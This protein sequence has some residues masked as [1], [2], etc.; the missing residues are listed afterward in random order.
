[1]D[2]YLLDAKFEVV[3]MIDHYESFI[4]SDR[5]NSAGEFELY[6]PSAS[7]L[8]KE[9][10]LGQYIC[11]NRSDRLMVVEEIESKTDSY[12]GDHTIVTG[13]SLESLLD[14]RVIWGF[15]EISGNLQ[16]GIQKLLNENVISPSESKRKIPGFTFKASSDS[17]VTS[18][19]IENTQYFGEVVYD[20][21]VE[22]CQAHD[23]GFRVLPDYDTVGFIFELYAGVDRSYNQDS[24][25]WVMFSPQY[26]NLGNSRYWTSKK[27]WRNAIMV[28]GEGDG[29][30]KTRVDVDLENCADTTGI[31]RREVYYSSSVSSDDGTELPEEDADG[32]GIIDEREERQYQ[33]AVKA[34]QDKYEASLRSDGKLK[35]GEYQTIKG[36]D[37][38]VEANVQFEFGKD[39]KLGDIIEIEDEYGHT[40]T[41]RVTEYTITHDTNGE[42]AVPVFTSTAEA[43][44]NKGG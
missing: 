1:M 23:L 3:A 32:D 21:I 29:A 36:F 43:E 4:W 24:N 18:V 6:L 27:D 8:T 5:Y 31:E 19:T 7:P 17:K 38:E 33:A 44:S 39:Y 10:K 35:L 25:G 42:I 26:D 28:G 41:S 22:L 34:K 14:R 40:G 20:T 30:S 9:I 11:C 13:R 12:E 2:A 15:T 37:G 16:N